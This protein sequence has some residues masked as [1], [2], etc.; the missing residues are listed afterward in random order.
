MCVWGIY[1]TQIPILK[2]GGGSGTSRT[3]PIQELTVLAY[4]LYPVKGWANRGSTITSLTPHTAGSVL[5]GEQRHLPCLMPH[6]LS[7]LGG[8]Q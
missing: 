3:L 5:K 7:R 4:R 8:K 6:C 2:L 1:S